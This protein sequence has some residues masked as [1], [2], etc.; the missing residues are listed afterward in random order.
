MNQSE[1]NSTEVYEATVE[2]PV[3]ERLTAPVLTIDQNDSASTVHRHLLVNDKQVNGMQWCQ[4]TTAACTIQCAKTVLS[5]RIYTLIF[6]IKPL[7]KRDLNSNSKSFTNSFL[8]STT[9]LYKKIQT[10]VFTCLIHLNQWS[11]AKHVI[12][13]TGL[14]IN[15]HQQLFCLRSFRNHVYWQ[16][17]RSLMLF[18]T[19]TH[20]LCSSSDR[21]NIKPF[22][23]LNYWESQTSAESASIST[24]QQPMFQLASH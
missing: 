10:A 7:Q 3:R 24:K 21:R 19:H 23:H 15:S 22:K 6:I 1:L 13:N 12:T 8:V 14:F 17:S 2:V 11:S 16:A 20:T 18:H 4:E 9:V 5:K